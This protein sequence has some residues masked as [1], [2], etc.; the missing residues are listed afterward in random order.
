M[1][2]R[3]FPEPPQDAVSVQ[4]YTDAHARTPQLLIPQV[5]VDVVS[6]LLLFLIVVIIFFSFF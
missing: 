2:T 5:G 6:L 4:L 3:G 1:V